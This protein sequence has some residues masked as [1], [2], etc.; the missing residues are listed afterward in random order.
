[1]LRRMSDRLREGYN[2]S[3]VALQRNV[4][5][6][7]HH[8][9]E[10]YPN[11]GGKNESSSKVI[12]EKGGDLPTRFPYLRI[13]VILLRRSRPVYRERRKEGEE[14]GRRGDESK[15]G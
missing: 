9:G 8:R 3:S 14:S 2:Q 10:S 11:R 5:L 6:F 15:I 12:V 7:R 4:C 1:M 13:S